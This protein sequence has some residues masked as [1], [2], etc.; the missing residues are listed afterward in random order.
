MALPHNISM[1]KVT[2]NMSTELKKQVIALKEELQISLS[3]IYNEAIANYL[4]QKERER[5]SKG[6]SMALKDQKYL[7]LAQDMGSDNGD[8][9]EY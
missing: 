2:F 5:W 4:E 9:Y 6:V 8:F 7:D 1:E 3:A